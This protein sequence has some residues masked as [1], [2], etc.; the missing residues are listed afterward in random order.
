MENEEPKYLNDIIG[1]INAARIMAKAYQPYLQD[2][3]FWD[4]AE[5]VLGMQFAGRIN[6]DVAAKMICF[7]H[8][9]MS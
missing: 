5:D 4:Q 3:L 9:R 6:V 1:D 2:R 7:E 8:S